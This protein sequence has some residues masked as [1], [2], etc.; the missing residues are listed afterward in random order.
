MKLAIPATPFIDGVVLDPDALNKALYDP[1]LAPISAQGLYSE[2]N[3]GCELLSTQNGSTTFEL[4]QEHIQP[5]QVVKTR[6]AGNW[7]ALDNFSN[8][9]GTLNDADNDKLRQIARSQALP[10]A[11]VRVYVPFEA[12]AIRFKPRLL[13]QQLQRSTRWF[14]FVVLVSG[15]RNKSIFAGNTLRRSSDRKQPPALNRIHGPAKVR[16]VL[17]S[18]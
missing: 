17:R 11:G 12:S 8:V 5:E 10:G 7:Y 1:I 6:Y 13:S 18:T 14:F 4:R 2:L 16:S 9:T 3:G 15:S